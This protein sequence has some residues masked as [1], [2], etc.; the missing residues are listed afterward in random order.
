MIFKFGFPW[1]VI[2][3]FTT[4]KS[5][6]SKE[7]LMKYTDSPTLLKSFKNRNKTKVNWKL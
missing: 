2:V 4:E 5:S 6:I 7:M 3:S 1:R